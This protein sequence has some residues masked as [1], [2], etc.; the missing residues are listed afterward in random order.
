VFDLPVKSSFLAD[1]PTAPS[2][3][4]ADRVDPATDAD[5]DGQVACHPDAT[6]FHTA[7]WARVLS[8]VYGH[9]PCFL[10]IRRAD[11][12]LAMVPM[13]EVRSPFTGARGVCMPF[14]D[15]CNPLMFGACDFDDIL[16]PLH[17]VGRG[18]NW[19]HIEIRGGVHHGAAFPVQTAFYQ[20]VLD[21]R[22][23]ETSVFNHL[24]GS[25]R[26]AIEKAGRSGLNATVTS[27][28]PAMKSFFHLHTATRRK[29]GLPPQPITFFK[30]IHEKI[31][32]AGNGFLVLVS[33]AKRSVAA[34]LFFKQGKQALFKAGASDYEYLPNRVNNLALWE[35]IRMLIRSGAER[36]SFGRTDLAHEGLRRF[37]RGWGGREQTVAYRRFDP[38]REE[39]VCGRDSIG[40]IHR[41]IFRRMPLSVNRMMGAILYPHLD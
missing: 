17:S 8:D 40:G 41:A 34:G 3:V 10:R 29:H 18:R 6:I 19:K 31:I 7:A 12:L 9:R 30:A 4:I 25:V 28:W 32:S 38:F 1:A 16:P 13:M 36:V 39:P 37:K 5:W 15:F 23:G 20:H 24:G 21:L 26:R 33:D 11:E 22:G 2:D 14:A 27:D 35:G